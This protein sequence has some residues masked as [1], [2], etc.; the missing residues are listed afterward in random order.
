VSSASI[1]TRFLRLS[2][3]DEMVFN[4]FY[5][6]IFTLHKKHLYFFSPSEFTHSFFESLDAAR[7]GQCNAIRFS[8]GEG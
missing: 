6:F 1:L 5:T 3:D 7:W 2:N 8:S 4:F